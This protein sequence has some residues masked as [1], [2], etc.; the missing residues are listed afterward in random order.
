M[1][2]SASHLRAAPG[3][4]PAAAGLVCLWA[5]AGCADYQAYEKCGPRGCPGDAE[6]TARVQAVVKEHPDL[7]PPNILYVHTVD[8]TVYLSGQMATGLQRDTVESL[9][10]ATPDVRRVVN[11]LALPYEGR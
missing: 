10:R 5:L 11:S 1:R 3:W 7:G 2:T 4:L 9:V 6:I 8:R